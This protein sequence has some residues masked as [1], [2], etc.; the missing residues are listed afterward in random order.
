MDEALG[1]FL[2]GRGWLHRRNPLPK[3]VFMIWGVLAPF[4]V[5]TVALPAFIAGQ[6]LIALSAGLGLT[7]LRRLVLGTLPVIASIILVNLFFYPGST[8]VLFS[9]GPFQATQEGLD[10]GLPIAAR[11]I[12]AVAATLWFLQSTRPDDLMET[13]VQRG[14]G[15]KLAFVVL[16]TIQ[17][18]PR[19]SA[20]ARR[21]LDAQQARGLRTGGSVGARVRALVPLVA[22]LVIGS[23]NDVRE[24][25]L[26]LE[27][28]AFGSSGLRTAYRVVPFDRLDRVLTWAAWLALALL[29]VY[30]V[31]RFIGIVP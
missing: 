21:I 27:A 1:F 3:F 12:A 10:F 15:P 29:P 23:L 16:S 9:I 19:M 25:A 14:A 13:L 22:P 24:R 4:V 18:V 31:A 2:P 30:V 6:V 11:L 17:T 28:R 26:A 20:K 5:S 8:H 7:Y